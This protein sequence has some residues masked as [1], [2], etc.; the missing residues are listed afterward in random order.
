MRDRNRRE[1]VEYVVTSRERHAH[2][3]HFRS[4]ARHTEMRRIL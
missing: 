4:L 3:R 1:R 2:S